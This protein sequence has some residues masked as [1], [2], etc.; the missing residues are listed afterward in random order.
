[1][2]EDADRNIVNLLTDI[3][4][5]RIDPDQ[6]AKVVIDEQSGIIVIG[7]NVRVSEIAIA[8]GQPHNHR[9]RNTASEPAPIRLPMVT[10][11][12]GAADN[13]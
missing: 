6:P 4:Q 8:Q 11:S 13:R 5:L 2:P 1:M 3:E 12:C 7:A 10:L 9:H